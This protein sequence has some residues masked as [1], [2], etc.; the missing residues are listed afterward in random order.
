[1]IISD[2]IGGLRPHI[3]VKKREVDVYVS[4][5]IIDKGVWE[6]KEVTEVMKMMDNYPE[7]VFLDLGANLGECCGNNKDISVDHVSCL[8]ECT[9]WWWQQCLD[10]WSLLI[11]FS[12][13]LLSFT[14]ACRRTTTHIWC[15]WSGTQSGV[16]NNQDNCMS[17]LIFSNSRTTYFPIT[18]NP[19]NQGGTNLV[20]EQ[21]MTATTRK[22]VAGDP[23]ES[24]TLQEL[25][26]FANNQ[27]WLKSL[28]WILK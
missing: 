4:G 6:Q 22:L 15:H 3:C 1:M 16:V 9:L 27:E 19:K 10:M 20:A 21:H 12:Q 24:I 7:A 8:K 14:K 5:S 2:Q 18:H 26:V 11:L 23:I 25:I 28:Y 17:F 13:I